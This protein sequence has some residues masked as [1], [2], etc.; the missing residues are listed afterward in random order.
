MDKG[1][2]GVSVEK[3]RWI[4]GVKVFQLRTEDG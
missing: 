4:K 1:C 2:C 3:R